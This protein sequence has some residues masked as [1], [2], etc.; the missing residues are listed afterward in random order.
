MAL[1]LFGGTLALYWPVRHFEFIEVYDDKLY[2]T[3]NAMVSAG[4]SW[5]GIGWAFRSG[6]ASNWHPLTWLSHMADCTIWGRNAGGHHLTNALFHAVNA[7]LVFLVLRRMTGAFWN[8]ALVAAL[9]ACHPLRVQSVAWIAERKD[10]LSGFFF[11]VT[12]YAYARHAEGAGRTGGGNPVVSGRNSAGFWRSQFYWL[13]LGCFALGLM[14]KPMLVTVPFVLLLLDYWPLR[15]LTKQNWPGRVFEKGPFLALSAVSSV[16][17]FVAQKRGGSVASWE[18]LP[19]GMRVENALVSYLRYLGKAFY[20]FDLAVI[21]PYVEEWPVETVLAAAVVL[22]AAS[23]GAWRLGRRFPHVPVGWFWFVGMLVPVIGLV[24]VG[25]QSI[26]DRYTYL[27]LLGIFVLLVWGL[28]E[29]AVRRRIARFFGAG[30]AVVALLFCAARTRDELRYWQNNLT[31]FQRAVEVSPRSATAHKNLGE[32]LARLGR[33]EEA[34]KC[35]ETA[36]TLNPGDASIHSDIATVL[37]AL[38]R[39]QEAVERLQI[40]LQLDPGDADYPFNLGNALADL[41]EFDAAIKAYERALE[42]N[43]NHARARNNL[44]IVLTR[45]GRVEE[46]LDQARRAANSDARNPEIHNTLANL[47]A[48][49]GEHA[50][51]IEHYQ[52]ALQLDPRMAR[53]LF[54]LASS[55]LA[56]GRTNDALQCL[57]NAAALDARYWQPRARLGAHYAACGQWQEAAA[58]WREA[59]R[60]QT[61]DPVAWLNLG[62][63]LAQLKELDAATNALHRA[64]EL[65]PDFAEARHLLAGCLAQLGCLEPARV[66]YEQLLAAN[67]NDARAHLGLGR[68]LYR[69]GRTAAAL[70]HFRAALER[71]PGWPEALNDTAWILATTADTTLRDPQQAVELA[72]RANLLAGTPQVNFLGTLAA[73]YAA[74]GRFKEA[75]ATAEQALALAEETGMRTFAEQTRTR[76]ERYR[77][78]LSLIEDPSPPAR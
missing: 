45:L 26:A 4:L 69:S 6:H 11:L 52:K 25:E 75:V 55:L 31:L 59:V 46:A 35:Y 16:V 64:L 61:N 60:L 47:L 19:F 72:Q 43:P 3:E 53:A 10:V 57:T 41:N 65:Q 7:M 44:A 21:Y 28:S 15:R 71:Q 74:A 70:G 58:W 51:A 56:L 36:L 2:I 33:W 67:P 32:A 42:L 38:G 17:T 18:L 20:P 22:G 12:L 62:R 23:L 27:P 66:E 73:A 78:G 14:S 30:L 8:A 39:A 24:Q 13:A 49:R 9:F 48:E 1:L 63:A 5:E 50:R 34:L 68:L 77:A 54:N 40:A 37:R 76:L 29:L